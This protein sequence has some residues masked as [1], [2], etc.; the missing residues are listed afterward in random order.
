MAEHCG[1]QN[2][3]YREVLGAISWYRR[4]WCGNMSCPTRKAI[5]K[6]CAAVGNVLFNHRMF[7]EHRDAKYMDVR[8]ALFNKF[9]Q[10]GTWTAIVSFMLNPLESDGTT[11]FN[12][13]KQDA[14][15]G[16]ATG[17]AVHLISARLFTTGQ[18]V[19]CMAHHW[20]FDYLCGPLWCLAIIR[21][22]RL[23]DCKG[24]LHKHQ[25]YLWG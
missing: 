11:P 21:K 20:R 24:H 4:F 7:L 25:H 17:L 23:K 3:Y 13:E 22:L 5:M 1:Y 10:N 19:W 18:L 2:A 14:P 15:H 9:W 12:Q 6:H 16:S 8:V